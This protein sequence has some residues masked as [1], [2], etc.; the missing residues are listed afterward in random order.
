MSHDVAHEM[1]RLIVETA[2]KSPPG[3]YKEWMEWLTYQIEVEQYSRLKIWVEERRDMFLKI[4]P[5]RRFEVI[6]RQ[7]NFK[8]SPLTK[9]EEHAKRLLPILKLIYPFHIVH[10]EFRGEDYL[11]PYIITLKKAPLMLRRL[12]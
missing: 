3:D 6:R 1:K 4:K 11:Y 2:Y 5:S 12:H 9:T 7:T 10:Y 8:I